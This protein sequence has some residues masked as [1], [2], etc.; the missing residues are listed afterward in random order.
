MYRH[1][2][3]RAQTRLASRWCVAPTGVGAAALRQQR[4]AASSSSSSSSSSP[5]LGLTQREVSR[6]LA[7]LALP[8]VER[9]GKALKTAYLAQVREHH[10]DH[11]GSEA[12]M[13]EINTAYD[14]L[15]A[16]T[17]SASA[18]ADGA[19][20]YHHGGT[21]PEE[22]G[23]RHFWRRPSWSTARAEEERYR[24]K[25]RDARWA[26]VVSFDAPYFDLPRA[27]HDR[28]PPLRTHFARLWRTGWRQLR[29]LPPPTQVAVA[30]SFFAAFV[31]SGYA[32]DVEA[33]ISRVD[34]LRDTVVGVAQPSDVAA[35]A[36]PDVAASAASHAAQLTTPGAAVAVC[37]AVVAELL[38]AVAVA[39]AQRAAAAAL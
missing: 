32:L 19:V 21:E 3:S 9:D 16:L 4:R 11:G 5:P 22:R 1:H 14:L 33:G 6:A 12:K 8:A 2:L 13:V 31:G 23:R 7:A 10:P 36:S 29:A 27:R 17:T 38:D 39:G 37:D 34:A 15:K 20:P 18:A 35:V 25:R 24:R 26:P 30:V 28:P